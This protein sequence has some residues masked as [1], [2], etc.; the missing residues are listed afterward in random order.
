MINALVISNNINFVQA[1]LNELNTLDLKLR[2]AGIST[3]KSRTIEL[4]NSSNFRIVFL[5]KSMRGDYNKNFFGSY[6][7]L[8]V[9]SCNPDSVTL[10]SP[11]SS[12][13]LKSAIEKSDYETIKR[14]VAKELEYIGYKFK[15]KGTHYLLESI[16]QIIE[17][18]N[19]VS[20]HLQTDV[21]PLVAKKFQKN[22][23]NIKSSISK[24]TECM[25][26]ECDS[27][28]LQSYF[29]GLEDAKPTIKQVIFTI[30]SNIEKTS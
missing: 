27:K 16:L 8:V 13:V 24:A 20:D 15:Y 2:I 10:I 11:K 29:K 3:S 4:L 25:Y 5:D 23:L 26:Y 22:P 9:F 18:Q 6:D 7:S 14:K 28:K 17:N 21:Y 30:I 12:K 1:L 19:S